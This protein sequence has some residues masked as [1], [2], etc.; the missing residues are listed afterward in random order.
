MFQSIHVLFIW[1]SS[2]EL[3]LIIINF[4]DLFGWV[5]WSRFRRLVNSWID[6][7]RWFLNWKALGLQIQWWHLISYS[8]DHVRQM[9]YVSSAPHLIT[10]V[11]A[12][13]VS[14]VLMLHKTAPIHPCVDVQFHCCGLMV[15]RQVLNLW[16]RTQ[17]LVMSFGWF[18]D[19]LCCLADILVN[20]V[21]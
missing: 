8:Q 12:C 17:F 15:A 19:N 3:S 4:V 1:L 20:F 18:W 7:K 5:T 21:R 16:T 11:S 2:T 6:L 13:H 14:L 10:V 9:L